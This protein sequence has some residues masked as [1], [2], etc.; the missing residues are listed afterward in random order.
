MGQTVV[1]RERHNFCSTSSNQ[2]L[3]LLF[4]TELDPIPSRNGE[5]TRKEEPV[6]QKTVV[7]AGT[8]FIDTH[9]DFVL[10]IQ[11]LSLDDYMVLQTNPDGSMFFSFSNLHS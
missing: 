10:V 4:I 5:K 1:P 11:K 2:N 7:K 3:T 8:T 9:I 6:V